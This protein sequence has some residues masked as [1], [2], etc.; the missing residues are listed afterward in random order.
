MDFR[1]YKVEENLNNNI[2]NLV[3]SEEKR[4][5]RSKRLDRSTYELKR[6]L[7]LCIDLISFLNER[8]T[9]GRNK[10]GN[11]YISNDFSV[12][13]DF[14]RPN[15][16]D[17]DI[18]IFLQHSAPDDF[19][20]HFYIKQE[21]FERFITTYKD[22]FYEIIVIETLTFL[23]RQHTDSDEDDEEDD[24]VTIVKNYECVDG[25]YP[26]VKTFSENLCVVCLVNKPNILYENCRHI[27][28]CSSCEKVKNLEK[29]SICRS[30]A[31]LKYEI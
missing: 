12:K 13:I 26:I 21:L 2:H 22:N 6:I 30:K 25:K 11:R 15:E 17:V 24:E 20:N 10:K 23:T 14:L 29:C 1:F 18:N 8:A 16:N 3:R 28:T 4:I 7:D 9:D 5:F 31:T 27:P 19:N